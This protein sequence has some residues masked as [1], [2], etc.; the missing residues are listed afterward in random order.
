LL[1]KTLKTDLLTL[2][3][4]VL[5]DVLLG[6]LEDDTTLL[7]LGLLLLLELS[8]ALLTSLLLGLALLEKSL[9]DENLIVGGDASICR[10]V[11]CPA[12]K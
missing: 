1:G 10:S 2:L 9:W 6:T 11:L 5:L 7:L 3:V 4:A 12:Y 8:S